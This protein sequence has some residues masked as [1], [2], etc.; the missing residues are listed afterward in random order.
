M[1]ANRH[2]K[3]RPF[4]LPFS[5]GSPDQ[6]ANGVGEMYLQR[7]WQPE[8]LQLDFAQSWQI[9]LSWWIAIPCSDH[10]PKTSRGLAHQVGYSR[11]DD[12]IQALRYP[13]R[14]IGFV[15]D[16]AGSRWLR[17]YT[18]RDAAAIN[19]MMVIAGFE[20]HGLEMQRFVYINEQHERPICQEG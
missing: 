17:G 10:Q 12:I 15:Y 19:T 14:L 5:G 6:A 7:H 2:L 3:A 9:K 13:L 4:S 16:Y 8:S 11:F 1:G 18:M 20:L